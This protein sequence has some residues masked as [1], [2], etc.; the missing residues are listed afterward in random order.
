[1]WCRLGIFSLTTKRFGSSSVLAR[2]NFA[3]FCFILTS[4]F[5][6]PA[7]LSDVVCIARTKYAEA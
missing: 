6:M 1:M 5:G 3:R 2:V 4:L 7:K